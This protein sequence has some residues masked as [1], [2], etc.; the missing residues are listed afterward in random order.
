MRWIKKNAFLGILMLIAFSLPFSM[1]SGLYP[2]YDRGV[3]R[4]LM[5]F[6]WNSLFVWCLLLYW[7]IEG[8]WK[9]KIRL[10]YAHKLFWVFAIYYLLQWVGLIYSTNLTEAKHEILVK[11]TIFLFPLIFAS[12]HKKLSA[13]Q[14]ESIFW[15][16]CVAVLL[17]SMVTFREGFTFIIDRDSGIPV[18]QKLVILHRPYLGMYIVFI[19]FYLFTQLLNYNRKNQEKYMVPLVMYLLLF[20]LI[21]QSKIA[22]IALFLTGWAIF[23]LIL[24]REGQYSILLVSYTL[25]FVLVFQN[26]VYLNNH[27]R[28]LTNIQLVDSHMSNPQLSI[29]NQARS[30]IWSC[31]ENILNKPQVWWFGLGTGDA[32]DSLL[33]CYQYRGMEYELSNQLNAH[34][35]FLQEF[36]RHGIIGLLIFLMSLLVPF[37][38]E[39][40]KY[41]YLYISFILI[42]SICAL[43][44]SILSRQAGVVFYAFFN[45]LL[46]FRTHL[47]LSNSDIS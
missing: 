42:I 32:E 27:I 46:V 29:H 25:I 41:N 11:S 7:I 43:T 24:F 45:A 5:N 18:L 12:T 20:L 26:Y 39:I 34:N 1:I 30:N 40:K 14:Y 13:N 4:T 35:E 44:E 31:V 36:L 16:F 6:Q 21:I 3:L 33:E 8:P 22:L 15:V 38:I 9:A 19:L 28:S 10:L 23:S 47:I 2:N 17:A 37:W